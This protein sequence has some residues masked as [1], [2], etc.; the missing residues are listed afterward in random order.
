MRRMMVFLKMMVLVGAIVASEQCEARAQRGASTYRNRINQAIKNVQKDIAA[1]Q[2]QL[3]EALEEQ[4]RAATELHQAQASY[5]DAQADVERAKKTLTDR[6]G[7]KVGLADA[8]AGAEQARQDYERATAKA[9]AQL[10][11]TPK[12]QEIKQALDEAEAHSA[13][14]KKEGGSKERIAEA[15]KAALRAREAY[16]S[17][18]DHDALVKPAREQV[19]A[20]EEHL[21]EVRTKLHQEIKQDSDLRSA[22]LFFRQAKAALD[23][24]KASYSTAEQKV[25]TL[26]SRLMADHQL[27]GR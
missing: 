14:L 3:K 18:I 22:E 16:R 2:K 24:A 1:V 6:L 8:V 9:V 21:K 11:S 15:S 19:T 27:I 12:Y 7:P 4:S 23:K 25:A 20:A 17:M 10:Q 26:Q 5:K 13:A